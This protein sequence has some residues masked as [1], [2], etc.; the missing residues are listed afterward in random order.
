M[1][2]K[3]AG[4]LRTASVG[5]I[6]F[7][8]EQFERRLSE[9]LGFSRENP[10]SPGG[11]DPVFTN[12]LGTVIG[13]YLLSEL[14]SK[15]DDG[16]RNE[17]KEAVTW[18]RF[19]E[20]EALCQETNERLAV[21]GFKGP[22]EQEI[23]LAR[24]IAAT[25]LGPL[26]LNVVAGHFGWGPGSTTRVRRTEADAAYKY[27][28]QPETTYNNAALAEAAIRHFPLW[29]QSI[30]CSVECT[31][32]RLTKEVKGNRVVTV[33]KNYKTDRTIAI[34]PCMNIYVQKGLGAVMRRRLKAAGCDLNDQTRNQRLAHI[35]AISGLLATIDLSMASDT[36]SREFVSRFIRPDWLTALEQSR[37]QFGVLPSGATLFYQKFS[38]MGNGYTFE[39]ESLIFYSLALAHCRVHGAETSRVSVY[40]DDI[41]VPSDV[42]G[43][44]LD[45]L[46]FCGFKPNEKKTHMTGQFRE[47][48]G[49]HY[50]SEHEVTPFYV[51]KPITTLEDLFLLHNNLYRWVV[52]TCPDRFEEFKLF[53]NSIRKCAP[54]KW[55][56]ARLPDGFGDGAFIGSF[57]E[58]LPRKHPLGWEAWV[59]GVYSPFSKRVDVEVSGLL[60][61]AFDMMSARNR[62]LFGILPPGD[63]VEVHPTRMTGH[64]EKRITV[65]WSEAKWPFPAET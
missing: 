4:S 46:R 49:K 62:D 37:S 27:S 22:F 25:I 55:R 3:R 34:E 32:D 52:R 48:C 20:A 13:S 53:L 47:S 23:L 14:F 31:D 11:C 65:A 24:K 6:R 45:L 12:G 30:R 1:D 28:G 16:R 38:S 26:D 9:Y 36:L 17:K 40:G 50:Y 51:R 61:K 43:S 7:G 10:G 42:A 44:F 21:T 5:C 63:R 18:E 29:E 56:R 2:R 60:P 39:L 33:P 8:L 54:A 15:F 58:A 41:I 19:H 64:R 57:D 35:G 59:I